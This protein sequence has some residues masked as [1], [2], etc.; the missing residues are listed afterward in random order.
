MKKFALAAFGLFAMA[1]AAFADPIEG[2]WRTQADDN[3]NSG[4][5]QIAP[6]GAAFCGVLIKSFDAS[7]A[8]F[9][10][11]NRGRQ[12]VIDMVPA[13][14]GEYAGQVW[15][16]DNNKTYIGKIS[17]NGNSMRLRGCVAG[18]LICRGQD[19]TRAN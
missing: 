9:E 17:L 13:G 14:D 4:L 11:E 19:W 3:G 2:L 16:P 15:S 12:I 6:C 10:S 5:V 8:E 7:G 18:G 1:T